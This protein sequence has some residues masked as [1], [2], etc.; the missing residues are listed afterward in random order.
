MKFNA[1]YVVLIVK[2]IERI[3]FKLINIYYSLSSSSCKKAINWFK[4]IEVE[5][6]AKRVRQISRDELFH[7]LSLSDSG[8]EDILKRRTNI[9]GDLKKLMNKIEEM[10]FNK[11]ID[12]ILNNPE[13][14]KVPIIFDENRL[15]IGFHAEEI[16]KFIPKTRRKIL[17]KC[18]K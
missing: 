18:Y 1:A 13:L 10:D 8:F 17:L 4:D 15:M 5:V 14:I 7:I 2:K 11:G 12:Y 3:Y 9:S 6:T 16:R